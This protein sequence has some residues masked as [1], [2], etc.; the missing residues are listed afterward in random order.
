LEGVGGVDDE[1]PVAM[2]E[3]RHGFVEFGAP[4]GRFRGLGKAGE[5]GCRHEAEGD[6]EIAHWRIRLSGKLSGWERAARGA[7]AI[8][9][10]A[11]NR[12]VRLLDECIRAPGTGE[13][14]PAFATGKRHKNGARGFIATIPLIE[15]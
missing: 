6:E 12:A 9:R 13:L 8:L 3:E 15:R 14:L 1:D 11:T 4:C 10:T 7:R 5:E 2:A